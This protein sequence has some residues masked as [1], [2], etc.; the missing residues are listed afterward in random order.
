VFIAVIFENPTWWGYLLPNGRA[1]VLVGKFGVGINHSGTPV[2]LNVK[3]KCIVRA[4][5]WAPPYLQ[6]ELDANCS[7]QNR[8][9]MIPRFDMIIIGKETKT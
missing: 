9:E 8:G 5:G 7:L 6:L 1:P 4:Y 2:L 3:T